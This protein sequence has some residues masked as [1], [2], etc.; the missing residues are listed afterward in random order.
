MSHTDLF[1]FPLCIYFLSPFLPLALLFFCQMKPGSCSCILNPLLRDDVI[2]P[3]KGLPFPNGL[4]AASIAA[5]AA[6]GNREGDDL[7][8][9]AAAARVY[10][11]WRA[12]LLA[13]NVRAD[14][15]T[16]AGPTCEALPEFD[17]TGVFPCSAGSNAATAAASAIGVVNGPDAVASPSLSETCPLLPSS[18][19]LLMRAMLARA[20]PLQCGPDENAECCHLAPAVAQVNINALQGAVCPGAPNCRPT[21][22][23]TVQSEMRDPQRRI[24]LAIAETQSFQ[25]AEIAR[26]T[27]D[28]RRVQREYDEERAETER[29]ESENS[30]RAARAGDSAG[31]GGGAGAVHAH[32]I[33]SAPT[34]SSQQ[35]ADAVSVTGL[36]SREEVMHFADQEIIAKT[37]QSHHGSGHH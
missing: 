11:E 15:P 37:P 5:R 26:V 6:R 20:A 25:S 9:R 19:F 4:D 24:Q 17:P 13:R 28:S 22:E 18:N 33:P 36:L 10:D 30:A 35:H 16:C 8:R 34:V 1:D 2:V 21:N 7:S 32:S 12:D 29:A 23:L 14:V 27:E 31:V 3:A